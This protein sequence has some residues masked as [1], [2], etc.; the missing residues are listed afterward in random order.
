MMIVMVKWEG[1]RSGTIEREYF[2]SSQQRGGLAAAAAA[3]S[4]PVSSRKWP[5]LP[6]SSCNSAAVPGDIQSRFPVCV[7]PF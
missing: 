1:G 2:F 3:G 6:A 4:P 7:R 5:C